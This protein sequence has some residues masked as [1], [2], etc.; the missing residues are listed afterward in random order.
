MFQNFSFFI[1]LVSLF[2]SIYNFLCECMH[3]K[4]NIKNVSL[5][6]ND[7]N[8]FLT[9]DSEISNCS[10]NNITIYS[11]EAIINKKHIESV[12]NVIKLSGVGVDIGDSRAEWNAISIEIPIRL[13]SYDSVIGFLLIPMPNDINPTKNIRLCFKTSRGK[14][15]ITCAFHKL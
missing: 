13:T 8:N 4:I 1:S 7:G 14:K 11:V 6:K 9:I 2:L 12:R 10:K 5:L 15:Y 3:L